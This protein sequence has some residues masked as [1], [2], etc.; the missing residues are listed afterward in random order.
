M[1]AGSQVWRARPTHRESGSCFSRQRQGNEGWL[2]WGEE[3]ISA[4]TRWQDPLVLYGLL[5]LL[6]HRITY[7]RLLRRNA[8]SLRAKGAD[9]DGFRYSAQLDLE[10]VPY[11]KP[12]HPAG[13]GTVGLDLGPSTSAIVPRAGEARLG[14]FCAAIAPRIATKRRWQRKLDR[15]LRA[16]NP[17]NYD[18]QGRCKRGCKTWQDSQG[19]Q[20]TRRR[21]AHQERKLAA[22]RKSLHGQMAYEIVAMGDTIITEK[23]SYRAWQRQFGRSVGLRAPGMFLAMLKR[24]VASTGGTTG[25]ASPP[26]VPGCRNIVMGVVPTSRSRGDERWHQCPCGIGP[27]QRDLYSAFLAAHLQSPDFPSLSCPANLGACGDVLAGSRRGHHPTRECGA[28]LA[29]KYGYSPYRSASAQ[30][31]CRRPAESLASR[32]GTRKSWHASKNLL[33]FSQE[34]LRFTA[35]QGPRKILRFS[36]GDRSGFA[37]VD[38]NACSMLYYVHGT[39]D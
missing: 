32:A 36:A 35:Y 30:K 33:G 4:P 12:K 39:S 22:Q 31:S 24:T 6:R 19:Y 9:R 38:M 27:V 23:I 1:D 13:E 26:S 25:R 28:G 17:Q 5:G 37:S 10:G 21:L 20:A 29:P 8:S 34:S 11:Q 16:N 14:L 3:R 18:E 7:V 2:V 15:K